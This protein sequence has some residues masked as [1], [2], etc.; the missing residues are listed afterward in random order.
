MD[1]KTK[2]LKYKNK[3]LKINNIKGGKEI[4][5]ASEIS[6]DHT[7]SWFIMPLLLKPFNDIQ[8]DFP[9]QFNEESI[10][11]KNEFDWIRSIDE[12]YVLI[13]NYYLQ[14]NIE[15]D[16]RRNLQKLYLNPFLRIK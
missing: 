15:L 3:Y 13:K 9:N 7:Y 8:V 14:N 16:N 4:P 10:L 6:N 11:L 5:H 12:I 1:Y 2:Y